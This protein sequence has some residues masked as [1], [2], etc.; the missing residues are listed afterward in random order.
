MRKDII[1]PAFAI[2]SMSKSNKGG[3][4]YR[5]TIFLKSKEA[6]CF[7]TVRE[8]HSVLSLILR[9]RQNG[10]PFDLFKKQ[11]DGSLI[12]ENTP[13]FGPTRYGIVRVSLTSIF[14]GK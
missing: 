7:K 6:A 14:T 3:W 5:M 10:V 9:A 13:F 12:F 4:E 11:Q 2:L 8:R 1:L